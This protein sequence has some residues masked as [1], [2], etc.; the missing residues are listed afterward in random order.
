MTTVRLLDLQGAL[1]SSVAIT[2]DVLDTANRLSNSSGTPDLFDIHSW[3]EAG[4]EHAVDTDPV[5]LVVVPGLGMRNKH[6]VHSRLAQPDATAAVRYLKAATAA[7]SDI[8]A[9]CAGVF[10]LAET[11]I[12]DHRRATTTWWLAPLFARR[13]PAVRLTPADLVVTDG[14][15]TTAGAAMAHLDLMLT[16]VGRHG[17]E[18]LARQCARYLVVDR[19]QSQ[20]P[21]VMP[22]TMEGADRHVAMARSW[23]LQNLDARMGV[24]DMA[25]AVHLTPRTFARRVRDVSNMSPARFLRRLRVER[26]VE[27]LHNTDLPVA[28]VARAVGYTDPTALRRAM[29]QELGMSPRTVRGQRIP[30]H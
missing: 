24:K 1:A 8:A 16:L 14:P 30:A 13:Y 21:Y 19:R 3:S 9:S 5:D 12:L 18:D 15:V 20:S 23:A 10:L 26:A 28:D 17:G 29:S 7:G 27:L 6:E 2:F 4:Q 11:G 25:A 22:E